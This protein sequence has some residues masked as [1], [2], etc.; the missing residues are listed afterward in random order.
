MQNEEGVWLTDE[1]QIGEVTKRY[2]TNIFSTSRGQVREDQ[3]HSF[4]N[5]QRMVTAE[6]SRKLCEP[7]TATEVQAAI[8]QM[9]PMKAPGPDGFHALFYQKF[10][11]TI[12]DTVISKVLKVFEEGKMEEGMNDTL[13]VLILK[14]KRPKKIED[15]RPISLCN[16]SAKIVMKILAN[17]LKDILPN[18]ILE[19]QS[20]FVPGRLI[21]DNILLAHEVMRYIKSMKR[22]KT[23]CFSIKTDMSK[24]YD[25]MEW[26]FL[27]QMMIKLGFPEQWTRLVMECIS[28]VRYKIKLNDLIIDIPPTERGL[29]QGDP[30]SPYLF[31]ICS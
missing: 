9:S 29:R 14:S 1:R 8:F 25:R 20:A 24:A 6:M 15:Y 19:M 23:G 7:V 2:F 31:L 18:I 11:H 21:S 27:K 17:R 10:W 13:I 4:S 12:K 5:I 16:V 3:N 28:S 22:Q 30:L 26:S